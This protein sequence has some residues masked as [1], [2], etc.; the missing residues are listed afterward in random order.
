MKLEL[1]CVAVSL[2]ILAASVAGCGDDDFLEELPVADASVDA[3]LGAALDAAAEAGLADAGDP[4][5]LQACQEC[6]FNDCGPALIA[7]LSD[8]TC[9]TLATCA[10]TSNCLQDPP[11]C[12]PLCLQAQ[13]LEPAEIIEQLVMLQQLATSCTGCFD[14]C[15]NAVPGGLPGL[16]GGLGSGLP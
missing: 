13:D 7:C 6:I 9:R 15:Q 3:S 2:S 10:I 12:I 14:V 5:A 16:D 1:A 11:S 8:E 4:G